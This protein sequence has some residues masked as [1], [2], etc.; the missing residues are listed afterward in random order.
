MIMVGNE[1]LEVAAACNGLSMLMSLAA[2][3]AATASLVPMANWKRL[4]LLPSIIP[5]ALGSNVLRIAA[6]AWCYHKFGAEV[7]SKYAHDAA[8]WLMM[9]TA[10]VLVGLELAIMSWLVVE[11]E[12]SGLPARIACSWSGPRRPRPSRA[13]H[14]REGTAWVWG[15]PLAPMTRRE[16]AEAVMRLI[17]AGRP[18]FFI[19][20]NTHYAML[21]AERPEL[22]AI[23]DRAAFLLADG[24][25]M[26]WASRRGPVPL[27]ERVAGSDLVYDLCEHA[28]RLGRRVYLLGGAEGVAEEAARRLRA[29]YPGLIVAGTACPPPGS[30]SGE[31]CRRLIAEVREA[32][33]DL[34]LVAL[35]QPKGEL[36]LDEHLDELGV[37][38]S[39]PGRGHARLRRRPGPPRPA[40]VQKIGMEWAFR[41]Y[42]DPAR[43][44]PRYA[45]NALFLL[46]HVARELA[47]GRPAS[48]GARRPRAGAGE[49]GNPLMRIDPKDLL[50]R[51][52]FG[53]WG[54]PGAGGDGYSI[55]LPMPMDMPFL[56]RFALEGLATLD[57]AHCRQIIVIPDGWGPDGG[58]GSAARSR[59]R[60]TPGSRWSSSARRPGSSSTRWARAWPRRPTPATGR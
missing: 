17:E 50:L 4:V 57:T 31:G 60:P 37:P 32:R 55:L 16:A 28:A 15:L 54:R 53:R 30:L 22:R 56:L 35:G 45:R 34:L 10:M 19:T 58:G 29:L 23:N 14:E 44:G 27:P 33:P 3:V 24:A 7:G 21:T 2:T 43:L 40:A 8:G 41:I 5:I 51:A 20:A 12:E 11:A 13:G 39:R 47:G 36:W 42:T 25:P 18:S 38:V 1:R 6:T 59:R 26:V 9:P 48:P 46:G 49:I 52:L